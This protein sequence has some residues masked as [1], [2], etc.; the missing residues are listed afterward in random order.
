MSDRERRRERREEE[1]EGNELMNGKQNG[2]TG[3]SER[4]YVDMI[5]ALLVKEKVR[6]T[7]RKNAIREGE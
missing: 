7:A 6:D 1:K 3:N 5:S 2:A 4:I